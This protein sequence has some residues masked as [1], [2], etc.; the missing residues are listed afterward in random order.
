MARRG[1]QC[2]FFGLGSV[3]DD[4]V[5]RSCVESGYLLVAGVDEAGRGPLAG[6]VV[7]AAVI[8]PAPCPIEGLRDSKTIDAAR[9]EALYKEILAKCVCYGV[10]ISESD[11]IDRVNILQATLLAMREAVSGLA[12]KPQILLVD[13]ISRIPLPVP[14][15]LIKKG[16]GRCVTVAAASIVAKVTRDSL[17][18][19]LHDH[20]PDYGFN[21]H[22]GYGTRHHVEAIARLG[23][24]PAHRK[25]F[26]GVKEYI[27]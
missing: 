23:P 22:F 26:R 6:P 14:Q 21:E 20:Y 7:A 2:G 25:T 3:P 12:V 10:G 8:L 11:L 15:K 4:S 18:R 19:K 5:E 9:R 1:S 16:D 13:G 24:C 27:E 17:M